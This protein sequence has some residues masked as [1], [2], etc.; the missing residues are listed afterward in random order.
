MSITKVCVLDNIHSVAQVYDRLEEAF[1]LPE[2]FGRNFDALYDC[3]SAD[4][5]GPMEI[6]WVDYQQ[7][8]CRLGEDVV[9]T[10]LNIFE[11]IQME[12]EDFKLVLGERK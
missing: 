9:D 8:A 11:D 3:L 4:V 1:S 10:L 5:E 6:R 7:A 2:Y 12:R